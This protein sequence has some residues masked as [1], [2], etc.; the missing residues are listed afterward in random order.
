MS[1]RKLSRKQ[2][3]RADKIQEE[4][5]NRAKKKQAGAELDSSAL[6]TPQE[7]QVIACFG[8]NYLVENR[9]A[10]QVT[11]MA[12]QNLGKIVVGDEVIWQ[13]IDPG[14]GI[15][16]ATQT[17]KSLLER[18][19]FQGNTRPVAANIDQMVIVCS[20]IPALQTRLIDRYLVAVELNN[21][22][23]LI[24]VNKIDLLDEA[25]FK[26]IKKSLQHYET[27]G[28]QVLYFSSK[29]QHGMS[30]L[31]SVLQNKV[32]VLVGQSGVGKSSTVKALL[33]EISI[34]IGEIS[35]ASQLGKHTTSASQL[36]HLPTGGDL[37]D[38]PGVRDFGLWH[39]P[40]SRIS[41]GFIDFRD[42][43]GGCKYSN[44]THRNE[45]QCAIIQAVKA[46]KIPE[47]R[48]KNYCEIYNTLEAQDSK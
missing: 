46:S 24:A 40:V 33:P 18:P 34:Q 14:N 43:L 21:I 36:Y 19:N 28:Y 41:W 6:G 35:Q 3:W 4:R 23:P 7:G 1:K 12:R 10:V 42:Y 29:T 27:I 17:R 25:A 8:V 5:I 26:A 37:I 38:S 31:E 20:P 22:P 11:C 16:T 45:P 47:I 48:W 30:Q 39:I 9:Q 32:S 44:C 13:E 2:S 15:I